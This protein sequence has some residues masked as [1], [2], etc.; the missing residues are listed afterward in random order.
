[1]AIVVVANFGYFIRILL[2]RI[3]EI[4]RL[5]S[6]TMII[7]D[8]NN[9]LFYQTNKGTFFS[10]LK[11]IKVIFLSLVLWLHVT[12]LENKFFNNQQ[13]EQVHAVGDE[14][15]EIIIFHNSPYG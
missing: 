4:D 12:R 7:L 10:L 2:R 1:M 6:D 15:R 13:N 5:L 3:Y 8:K 11:T 9:L 14:L